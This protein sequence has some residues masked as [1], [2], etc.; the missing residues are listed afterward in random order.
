MVDGQ[1][2]IDKTAMIP[3]PNNKLLPTKLHRLQITHLYLTQ[4]VD[5]TA[6]E[7]QNKHTHH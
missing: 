1:M 2:A 5:R 3:I 7:W 6:E 4:Q